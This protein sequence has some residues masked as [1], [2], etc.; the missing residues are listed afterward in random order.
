MQLLH[1]ADLHLGIENYGRIDPGTGLHS[2]LIDFRT[3]LQAVFDT[4]IE[5]DVDAVLFAGDLYRTPTPNPTWQRE[6]A[7]QL[8]R[9]QQAGIPLILVVGNHDTPAAFGRATSVDVF[10]ALDLAG[11]HV[12]R[13]PGLFTL[14]TQSGPL[15]IAGLP[16]PTRH[17]LR[18]DEA[19]RQLSQEDLMREIGRLCARQIRDFAER[20]EKETPAVLIAHAAAAGALLSGSERTALIGT[21]PTL[22]TSDL[23]NPAFD[24]VALG[25]VHRHQDLNAGGSP[26]VVYSGSVDRVDFGE[27][28]EA[29]GFCCVA[30]DCS[31]QQRVTSYEFLP[32]PARRFATL[33]VDATQTDDP[34][35]SILETIGQAQLADAVVRVRYTAVTGQRVDTERVR[36]ALMEAGVHHVAAIVPTATT[37][38]RQRRVTVPQDAATDVALARFIDNRPDL[39]PHRQILKRYALQLE[40]DLTLADGGGDR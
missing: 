30:I 31:G 38:E 7:L 16:W 28:R 21:D 35:A 22:L 32:T 3:C 37:R 2:R 8:H 15:Q 36:G 29:K 5:R 6:F 9:L 20:L 26:A 17:Y 25:H 1:F 23:A 18:T 40:N 10:N 14:D 13:S 27:E 34:T 4:A 24:Y 12:V 11:T 19:Y 39:E 33:D